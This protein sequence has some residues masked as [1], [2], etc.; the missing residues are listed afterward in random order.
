MA[1]ASSPTRLFVPLRR[2]LPSSMRSIAAHYLLD[3]GRLLE[4]PV[5]RFDE[6]GR[7]LGVEQWQSLDSLPSTEFYAG[8]LCAGDRKSV[9]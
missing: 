1:F 4:R 2:W 9:V 5:V 7:V 3:Q 8:A 6:Q